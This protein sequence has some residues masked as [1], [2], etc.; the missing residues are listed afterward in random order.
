M[1]PIFINLHLKL[2]RIYHLGAVT[3][4]KKTVMIWKMK[5]RKKKKKTNRLERR[6][7]EVGEDNP[8]AWLFE[9][10]LFEIWPSLHGSVYFQ[11]NF[12]GQR[13]PRLRFTRKFRSAES[14]EYIGK[15]DVIF[16]CFLRLM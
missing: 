13:F 6:S 3:I 10:V 9:K 2:V 1:Q 14:I 16:L 15:K 5:T 11:V 7:R 8:C 4:I 12:V